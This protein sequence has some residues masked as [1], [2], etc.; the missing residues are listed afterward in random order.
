[1]SQHNLSIQREHP[2]RHS[3]HPLGVTAPGTHTKLPHLFFKRHVSALANG[4]SVIMGFTINGLRGLGGLSEL[5]NGTD[6]R[7][8]RHLKSSTPRCTEDI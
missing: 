8:I 3:C 7:A 4:V 5:R 2:Q 6:F 1:M